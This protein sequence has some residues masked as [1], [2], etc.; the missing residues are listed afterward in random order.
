MFIELT[1]ILFSHHP[2]RGVLTGL[3]S[4]SFIAPPT[5]ATTAFVHAPHFIQEDS[6]ARS[7]M[8]DLHR[9]ENGRDQAWDDYQ[10]QASD[11]IVAKLIQY[12]TELEVVKLAMRDRLLALTLGHGD[13]VDDARVRDFLGGPIRK[14]QSQPVADTNELDGA[15][16]AALAAL[17]FGSAEE[18]RALIQDSIRPNPRA[19]PVVLAEPH[20]IPPRV[21][22]SEPVFPDPPFLG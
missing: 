11:D 17:D 8:D 15:T 22:V 4:P 3:N 2:L 6:F 5:M 13:D 16:I 14:A 7:L 18:Q 21:V 12:N 9:L 19:T 20:S 10:R 1:N